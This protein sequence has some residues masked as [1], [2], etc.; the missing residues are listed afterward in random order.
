MGSSGMGTQRY[1]KSGLVVALFA[2]LCWPASPSP[3][4]CCSSSRVA[5]TCANTGLAQS[6]QSHSSPDRHGIRVAAGH[7]IGAALPVTSR[8]SNVPEES[9]SVPSVVQGD[10]GPSPR[11]ES[12][13]RPSPGSHPSKKLRVKAN[14]GRRSAPDITPPETSISAGPASMTGSSSAKFF[15]AANEAGSS[16]ECDLDGNG[17]ESCASPKSYSGLLLGTHQ[18]SVRATDAAGNVDPT[19]ATRQWTIEDTSE[20]PVDDNAAADV[21]RSRSRG[22]HDGNHRRLLPRLQRGKLELRLQPRR[23][24]LGTLPGHARPTS[25]SKPAEHEFAARAIDPNGN[26]DPTRRRCATGRSKNRSASRRPAA[27]EAPTAPRWSPA[28]APARSAVSSAA[29]G[30]PSAWPTAPTEKS[31]SA[32]P[33]PRRVS[34][35]GPRTPA[36]QRS[37][38]PL[39]GLSPHPGA[40]RHHQRRLIQAGADATDDRTQPHHRR[41]PGNRRLHRPTRTW[42]TE[43]RIVGNQL[44]GPFGEDAIH[45]NRYHGLYV[46][47]NEITQVRENGAHS[48][49]LQTVWRGDHISSARTTCTTTAARASS[50]RTRP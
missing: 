31:R 50:S 7:A 19:P 5:V 1:L 38:A 30:P 2:S 32:P 8:S 48:D 36:R 6:A 42:C 43:M 13:I 20:P 28:S 15:F 27:V 39:S 25:N 41:R 34:P 22:E 47:G 10:R 14:A 29:A 4:P 9:L 16:F 44:V 45:A 26:V 3:P 11:P 24:R 49:C 40:L 17:W 12:P 33:R 23:R 46:E 18:F 21:D 35:C 37:K